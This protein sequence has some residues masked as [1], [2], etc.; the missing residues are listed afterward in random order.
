MDVRMHAH[1]HAKS[2]HGIARKRTDTS[3]NLIDPVGKNVNKAIAIRS[4]SFLYDMRF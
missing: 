4:T 3:T 1:T 2:R